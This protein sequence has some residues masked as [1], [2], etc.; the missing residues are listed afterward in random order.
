MKDSGFAI[1]LLYLSTP[2][3]WLI[4]GPADSMLTI[5]EQPGILLDLCKNSCEMHR[6]L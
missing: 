3:V 4:Y 2:L 6:A 1:A 5:G